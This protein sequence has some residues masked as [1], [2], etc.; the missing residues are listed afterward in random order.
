[1][2]TNVYDMLAQ[3]A[4]HFSPDQLDMLFSKFQPNKERSLLDTLK[5]AELLKRLAASDSEV[6][7]SANEG[8][9]H[10]RGDWLL[11]LMLSAQA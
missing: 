10:L 5:L 9:I 2:K 3:V 4:S 6:S 1:M 11:L 8:G 7:S